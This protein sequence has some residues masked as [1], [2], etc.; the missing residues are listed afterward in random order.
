M[1][2][3]YSWRQLQVIFNFDMIDGVY[4]APGPTDLRKGI[5]GYSALISSVMNLDPFEKNLYLF[6]NRARD[7]IKILYWDGSG[8][9]LFYKRLESGKFNWL[10]TSESPSLHLSLQQFRWLM[11][12]LEINQKTAFKPLEN[13]VI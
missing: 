5:D 13:K 7:K 6:C 10:K 11:E 2:F 4:M 3:V 12:G 8:F 9:W 1:N